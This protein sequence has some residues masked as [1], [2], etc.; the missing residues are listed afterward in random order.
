LIPGVDATGDVVTCMLGSLTLAMPT[1]GGAVDGTSDVG[2]C[3]LGIVSRCSDTAGDVGAGS[4]AASSL[5]SSRGG[6]VY[7]LLVA[8]A[9]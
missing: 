8:K 9:S 4:T 1:V 5:T 6:S 3:T 2:A 7:G